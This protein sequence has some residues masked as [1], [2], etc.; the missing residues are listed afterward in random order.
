M[1][2]AAGCETAVRFVQIETNKITD[3]TNH[4]SVTLV[5]NLKEN[6]ASGSDAFIP[7]NCL[8]TVMTPE[9]PRHF[10]MNCKRQTAKDT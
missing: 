9:C 7:A 5:L 2:G 3:Q 8:I 10:S 4:V 1:A 6:T